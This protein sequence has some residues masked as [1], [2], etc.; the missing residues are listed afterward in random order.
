MHRRR[1]LDDMGVSTSS[2]PHG[3]GRE[4]GTRYLQVTVVPFLLRLHDVDGKFVSPH[5]P[6]SAIGGLRTSVPLTGS[7]LGFGNPTFLP[8]TM[9][10]TRPGLLSGSCRTIF[11]MPSKP[12]EFAYVNFV[13]F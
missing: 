3:R 7:T 2:R 8:T 6:V 11:R 10:F 5:W 1:R 9:N 4:E 13:F 12:W